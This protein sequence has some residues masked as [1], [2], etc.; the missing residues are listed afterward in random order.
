MNLLNFSRSAHFSNFIL[1]ILLFF[2]WEYNSWFLQKF[3]SEFLSDSVYCLSF[4]LE[5]IVD[6]PK[7]K[8]KNEFGSRHGR[9]EC[10]DQI[11]PN[12]DR[13]IQKE[14]SRRSAEE[15]KISIEKSSKIIR[16]SSEENG[17]S[18][19]NQNMSRNHP[20]KAVLKRV[21]EER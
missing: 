16:R 8:K 17:K 19:L 21:F 5:W 20:D 2:L 13:P 3:D 4:I 9:G 14:K 10:R 18:R 1:I 11:C 15:Q 6:S 12:R 7:I